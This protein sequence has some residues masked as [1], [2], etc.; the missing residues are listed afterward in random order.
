MPRKTRRD[1]FSAAKETAGSGK[2]RGRSVVRTG[3]VGG[4]DAIGGDADGRAVTVITA[5]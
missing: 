5:K 1:I 4:G 2:G 3:I